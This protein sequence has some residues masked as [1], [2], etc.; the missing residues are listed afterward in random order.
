MPKRSFWEWALKG[1]DNWWP[2][3]FPEE[4]R[5]LHHLIQISLLLPSQTPK[6]IWKKSLT[7]HLR[8]SLP[9]N[10][11]LVYVSIWVLKL[12]EAGEKIKPSLFLHLRGHRRDMLVS[13]KQSRPVKKMQA[14]KFCFVISQLC[15]ISF[16]RI[17]FF[18]FGYFLCFF[19]ISKSRIHKMAFWS[20]QWFWWQLWQT[21]TNC[22][23]L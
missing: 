21:V 23:K 2:L 14:R 3:S 20:A 16:A 22:N 13:E 4:P 10:N 1:I 5:F 6:K 17:A 15:I 8:K 7:S 12:K 9:W 19:A 11:G 18:F